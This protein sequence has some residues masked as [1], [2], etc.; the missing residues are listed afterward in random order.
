MSRPRE[1]DQRIRRLENDVLS[2]YSMLGDIRATQD[3]HT[4]TLDRHSAVLDRHTAVLDRHSAVL[5]QHT[6][7]L[8]EHGSKLDQILE[9]L[10]DRPSRS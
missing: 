4:T 5:D 7:T 9:L 6:A 8:A 1:A 3:Q 10:Q 2:I